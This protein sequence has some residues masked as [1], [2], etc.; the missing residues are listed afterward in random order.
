MRPAVNSSVRDRKAELSLSLICQSST[1]GSKPA[2]I[3][4]SS[5]C[6][7]YVGIFW[8]IYIDTDLWQL[9]QLVLV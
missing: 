8:Q 5:D 7:N 2:K 4:I 3:F 6:S 1:E 9:I